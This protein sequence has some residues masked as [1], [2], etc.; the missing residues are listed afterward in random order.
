M[1]VAV[2]DDHS[3]FA[4]ALADALR[5]LGHVV[6]GTAV[7]LAEVV[8]LVARERPEI[9]LLDLWFDGLVSLDVAGRLRDEHPEVRVV[10]LT[11]D[12]AAE[13]AAAL[14]SGVVQAVVGKHWSL[15][16]I[17]HTLARVAAGGQ[18]HRLVPVQARDR[19]PAAPHLTGREQEVLSLL[20]TGASTTEMRQRLEVSEH[21]IRTHVRSVL[22]KL[23]VHSRV[24]AL[25]VAHDRGLVQ[26]GTASW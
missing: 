2:C 25:R 14:D 12:L 26:T 3:M 20:A 23:G 6:V 18:V 7:T 15:A 5:R 10:L 9:C 1:R 13:A 17:D 24:E 16:L 19:E 11:A 21:T 4:D 8:D 22:S